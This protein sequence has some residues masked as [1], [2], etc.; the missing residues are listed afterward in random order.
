MRQELT[1]RRRVAGTA[2]ASAVLLAG[3]RAAASSGGFEVSRTDAEWRAMLT[4]LQYNAMRRGGTERAFS[5]PLDRE[6]R[7]GM[8][9]CRGCAQELYASRHK[10]DSGTGWPSYWQPVAD[11]L[12]ETKTDF[13]LIYPRTECHCAICALHM[14]HVFNDGPPPTGQRWCIN[15]VVLSFRPFDI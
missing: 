12:V 15:G 5:S 11:N 6:S 1:R 7:R 3:G 8:F 10:Y 14:G 2:A 9:H 13:K 4:D